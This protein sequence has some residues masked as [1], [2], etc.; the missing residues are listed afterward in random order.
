MVIVCACVVAPLTAAMPD[1]AELPRMYVE[2]QY[3][4]PVLSRTVLTVGDTGTYSCTELQSAIDDASPGDEISIDPTCRISLRA[5]KSLILR[6]K[7]PTNAYIIIRTA[8]LSHLPEGEQVGPANAMDMAHI[9]KQGVEAALVTEPGAHHYRLVGLEITAD[10]S[11]RM[12]DNLVE[13]GDGS[14]LQS[15]IS[16]VPHHII[17]DRSYIHGMSNLNLQRCVA[18]N[19]ASS[20]IL[21]SYISDAHYEG[22]D[23]QAIDGWNGPGPFKIVNNYLEAAGENVMFG[24]ADP[25][26]ANLVPSDVEFRRN[27]VAK[28]KAWQGSSWTVKN[29]LELKNAQRVWIDGNVFQ[30]NWA[31]AQ[32]GTAIVLTPRDQS[33]TCPWCVVQD[34][35]FTNNIVRHSAGGFAIL[36]HDNNHISQQAQ[37][38]TIHNNLLIDIGTPQWGPTDRFLILLG[39]TPNTP[40]PSYVTFDHNT[41]LG[42]A[43]MYVGERYLHS[44]MP[45]FSFT[46]NIVQSA[47]TGGGSADG[48]ST[49]ITYFTSGFHFS[50]NVLVNQPSRNYVQ[51]HENFFPLTLPQVGFTNPTAGDYS[52]RRTSP[53][54]TKASDGG[55]VGYL[56]ND[57]TASRFPP[58]AQSA[59]HLRLSGP[60]IRDPI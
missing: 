20:A 52:L 59:K 26:I 29:L 10:P 40:G 4:P 58:L 32:S 13:L 5:G 33:G 48:D 44:T 21:D 36:G 30:Y 49:F 12:M 45:Y 46:N 41:V 50:N 19:S 25:A 47:L 28:N 6:N 43:T 57:A 38:I 23:S 34:V 31:Q 53:Y 8:L 16:Q 60:G 15:Q 24:G 54:R 18:L 9:I 2:T 11:N 39:G 51:Y 7:V 22:R 3:P 42:P 14:R 56:S 37:R 27:L 17:I 1:W 55:A 35:I